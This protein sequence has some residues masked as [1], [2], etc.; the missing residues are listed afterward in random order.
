M[1]KSATL[2]VLALTWLGFKSYSGQIVVSLEKKF[3]DT[4]L[5]LEF[6]VSIFTYVYR[7]E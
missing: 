4:F 7:N 1:V 5:C 3:Y 6:L 2:M